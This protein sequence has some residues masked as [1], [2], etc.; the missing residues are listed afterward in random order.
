MCN[1]RILR[2]GPLGV[3]VSVLIAA[4]VLGSGVVRAH[5]AEEDTMPG[6]AGWRLNAAAALSAIEAKSSW[7]MPRW[8]GVLGSGQTVDDRRGLHVEHAMAGGAFRADTAS[9]VQLGARL[10]VGWHGQGAAHVE[11]ATGEARYLVG[12]DQIGLSAGRMAMPMGAALTEA[13][14]LDRHAQTPLIRRAVSDSDWIDDG[15]HLR[16]R[17]GDGQDDG[18]QTVGVGLWR[19]K[20]FPGSADAAVA[21]SLHLRAGQGEWTADGFATR[22]APRSRGAYAASSTAGHTHAQPDCARSL[23]GVTCFD[24]RSVVLGAS[25]RWTPHDL[26]LTLTLAG[27]SQQ[28]RGTLDSMSGSAAYR[29]RTTGGWLDAV[30]SL[31]A[32]W[33]L[34]LRAER[35]VARHRLEGPGATGVALDAGLATNQPMHRLAGS[36]ALQ[37]SEGWRVIAEAGAERGAER[38]LR[39]V[40][41]R[42]ITQASFPR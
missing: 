24:G 39:W 12:D 36:V 41:L 5:E 9:G 34:G 32:R 7:P 22:L 16:W 35:L 19:A 4:G 23:V 20:A 14:H 27:L 11:A 42:L 38:T 17:R 6:T 29:G 37:P 31:D 10:A 1:N 15:I 3:L 40:G 18:L 28:E 8:S 13:G 33:Q 25:L 30:W 26:P 2:G 21:P